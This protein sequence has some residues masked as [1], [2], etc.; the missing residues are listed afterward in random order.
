M[1]KQ[2]I[3]IIIEYFS[4]LVLIIKNFENANWAS[5]YFALN[6]AGLFNIQVFI[7]INVPTKPNLQWEI[8]QQCLLLSLSSKLVENLFHFRYADCTEIEFYLA[9]PES[10]CTK[11]QEP[12]TCRKPRVLTPQEQML[13]VQQRGVLG[14]S[15]HKA[16]GQSINGKENLNKVTGYMLFKKNA[17]RNV[18]RNTASH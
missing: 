15:M 11:S 12:Q 16:T 10:S 17:S 7:I 18:Q 4:H 8:L 5:A 3:T 2:E 14:R 6:F 1:V 13:W 9:K